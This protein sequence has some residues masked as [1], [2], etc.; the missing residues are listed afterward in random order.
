MK[1]L[2]KIF[3]LFSLL[4]LTT[5]AFAQG[6]TAQV[7]S[8]KVQVGTPF[9]F[10][11]VITVYA[12]NYIPPSFK[13][14]DVVSGPNQS[15]SIQYVNGTMSQQLTISY[16]LVAKKEGKF[17]I[18]AASVMANGQKLETSPI[19]IEAVKGPVNANQ[20]SGEEE[21]KHSNRIG[22]SDLFIRTA[23]SKARCYIGEQ[24]TIT[25]K[26]YSRLQIVGFQKF[27]QPTYEG[28]YSQAQE[29]MS[30]GQVAVENLDGVNYYT[31]ELFRTIGTA[32]KAGKII[33]SPVEGDVVVRRQGQAK[34]K[35]IFEQFF[36][37]PSYEDVPVSVK[38]RPLS[39]EVL[40]LPEKNKPADFNGAVGDF[41]SKV[42]V[43]RNELKA[44]EAFNLKVSITGKGNLKLIDAP[45]YESPESFEVYEPK[46]IE[47]GNTKTFDYLVI[48]RSEG[49]FTLSN[50]TFSFFN[51]N[52]RDYVTLPSPEIHLKVHP[53]DANSQGAQVYTPQSQVKE[54]ENDIRYI[55]K[56]SFVL[57]KTNHE[58]FNSFK[59][60]G[61]LVLILAS[62]VGAIILRRQYIK[63]N[64][65]LVLVKERKAARVARKQLLLAEKYVQQNRKDEFYTEILLAL[66]NYIGHKLNIPVSEISRE[67]IRTALMDKHIDEQL[68]LELLN[69]IDTCEYAK[70]APGTV[71]ADLSSVYNSTAKL[72]TELEQGLNKRTYENVA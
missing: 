12:T 53:A 72:I 3:G 10:A 28:F 1:A 15:S 50:F 25:Q 8:K 41:S 27:A 49:D 24:I 64:S 59:H 52:S 71:S 14:F 38:S 54:A 11:V 48:P 47:N 35:N 39:V 40:S 45:K 36:G 23:A 18:G 51:L 43:N 2:R 21:S 4:S 29:S 57:Q 13:D 42:T 65:N 34:A 61:L 16:G 20:S 67:R 17:T 66:N 56:G 46:I 62:L 31:Y 33:L 6:F 30:K 60:I 69:T 58:F 68:M 63:Q 9:E 70:Y 55:K 26:V 44:N 32:N 5:S 22:G 19:Q 7:S 37:A